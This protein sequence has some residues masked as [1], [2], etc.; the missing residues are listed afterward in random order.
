MSIQKWAIRIILSIFNVIFLLM[1]RFTLSK[2]KS[3]NTQSYVYFTFK[4]EKKD[5]IQSHIWK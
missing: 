3:A 5:M 2:V 4:R 1:E